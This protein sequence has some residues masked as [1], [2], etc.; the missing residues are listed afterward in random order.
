MKNFIL[1]KKSFFYD[2]HTQKY[3]FTIFSFGKAN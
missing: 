3:L 1:G 2:V